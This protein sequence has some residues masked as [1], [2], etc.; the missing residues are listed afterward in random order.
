MSKR[1]PA[2][3]SKHSH[4]PKMTAKA[5]RAA[6]AIVRSPKDSRLHSVGTGSTETPPK[7]HNDSMQEVRL[8][9]N[10]AIGDRPAPAVADLGSH[11]GP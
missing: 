9:E 11:F 10:P 2:M 7:S 6:Q 1:K 4:S 3:A 8:V 5:Q